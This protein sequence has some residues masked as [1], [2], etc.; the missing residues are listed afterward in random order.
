MGTKISEFDIYDVSDGE[1]IFKITVGD[2]TE[3]RKNEKYKWHRE[4]GPARIWKDGTKE[5]W[6]NGQRHREDG[7]AIIYGDGRMRWY[8]DYIEYSEEEYKKEIY[9]RNL[10][11]L[12]GIV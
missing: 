2:V 7:P 12:N 1:P 5:W 3:Y 4:D 8:I 10:N 6:I 9:N 11:K